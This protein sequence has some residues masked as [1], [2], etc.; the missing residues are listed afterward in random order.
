M[1]CQRCGQ[2]G[3]GPPLSRSFIWPGASLSA[4]LSVN[5]LQYHSPVDSINSQ[6]I[7][8]KMRK[9]THL[10]RDELEVTVQ[11]S[12]SKAICLLR[13]S[14]QHTTSKTLCA[15]LESGWL[16]GEMMMKCLASP[17][18]PAEA[19]QACRAELTGSWPPGWDWLRLTIG[20]SQILSQLVGIWACSTFG[21]RN[22]VNLINT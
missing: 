12:T 22:A 21:A 14:I 2:R 6:N 17:S 10:C 20:Y 18:C 9:T 16:A 4:C 19:A 8:Q 11:G 13:P 7:V 15:L 3:A 1:P 5:N